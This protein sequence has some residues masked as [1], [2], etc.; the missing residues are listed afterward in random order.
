M[1]CI[2]WEYLFF[3]QELNNDVLIYFQIRNRERE[4]LL[5]EMTRSPAESKKLQMMKRLPNF[6]KII[7]NMIVAEKKVALPIEIVTS[8]LSHSVEGISAGDTMAHL[9]LMT[10]LLP[11]WI[12]I[13]KLS[14]SDKEYIRI[15]KGV[16]INDLLQEI[17]ELIKK[18]SA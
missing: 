18:N 7:R 12:K 5:K 9:R 1:V 13:V 15:E 2:I 10:T 3:S 14:H 6:V 16:D 17:Q 8:R 4:K 11:H